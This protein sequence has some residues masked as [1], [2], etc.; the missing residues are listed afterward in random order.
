MGPLTTTLAV[1]L[2]GASTA[3]GTVFSLTETY[4]V[5]NFFEKFEF[6]ESKFGTD[7]SNAQ[8]PNGGFVNYKSRDA[9]IASGLVSNDTGDV[10]I[11]VDSVNKWWSPDGRPS[12]R[13]ESKNDYTKGLFIARFNHLP[14]TACGAWPAF[15][16]Y[17]KVGKWPVG[18]E[19]DI[20]ENWNLATYNR[21][22]V[23]TG[24]MDVVGRCKMESAGVT[25]SLLRS[26]CSHEQYNLGC[27][28]MDTK[29]PWGSSAGGVYA[30]E[31]TDSYIRIFTWA[32]ADAPSNIDSA[33]PDT[34]AWGKPVMEL[35]DGPCN[36]KRQFAPQKL[37]LNIDFCGSA[38]GQ[39]KIWGEECQALT[40]E[41]ECYDYVRNN[42]GAYKDVYWRVKDIRYFEEGSKP[43]PTS[44]STT[45]TSTSSTTSVTTS[46]LV[47]S[48][49]KSTF[50]SNSSSSGP[51]SS[52]YSSSST[53]V[54]T[55]LSSVISSVPTFFPNSSV[56]STSS[57]AVSVTTG[58]SSSSG[59]SAH[60]TTSSQEWTTSTVYTTRTYTITSCA[61]TVINCPGKGHVVTETIPLYTTV[62]PVTPT[63]TTTATSSHSVSAPG[64]PETSI[65]KVTKTYT[66][67]S[68]A[69]T[70]TNC[71]V[72]RV[73]TEVVT[74]T[75]CPECTAN[76][77]KKPSTSAADTGCHGDNC[78]SGVALLL[79][80][81]ASIIAPSSVATASSSI[82]Q[83][84][85]TSVS[86]GK[87]GAVTSGPSQVAST[88]IAS[89]G[90]HQPTTNKPTSTQSQVPVTALASPSKSVSKAVALLA[91]TLFAAL[92]L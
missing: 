45:T 12:I 47:S 88:G 77:T 56:T 2:A 78:A 64:Q 27:N 67:T 76:N 18:G 92:F 61:P 26:D 20:Y 42:P 30:M 50:A 85:P 35:R 46:S 8:D 21:P 74:S 3:S 34:A 70:V 86:T 84:L 52:S 73:T 53:T 81:S 57:S 65:T 10:Y 71:P 36:L 11:G 7:N 37:I 43:D 24:D 33:H 59:S 58:S 25:G 55:S 28:V 14:K 72:G 4:D 22:T 75:I 89:S 23:H 6:F 51:T 87:S 83:L 17:S 13:L 49:V 60:L 1:L 39:P 66:I 31:W 16:T 63:A 15:W 82:P 68:C 9:A 5:T 40:G 29:G 90:A 19:I 79:E 62:C 54:P 80:Q 44:S 69:P 91:G 38:A 32:P 48:S 41:T